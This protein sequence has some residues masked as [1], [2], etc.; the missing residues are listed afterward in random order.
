MSPYILC[1]IAISWEPNNI[2][3]PNLRQQY[4]PPSMPWRRRLVYVKSFVAAVS[5]HANYTFFSQRRN[6][7]VAARG[8]LSIVG[9]A[10]LAV[11]I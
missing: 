11:N 3:S 4:L 5:L 8:L 6:F 9:E 7:H 10:M 1:E 2:H